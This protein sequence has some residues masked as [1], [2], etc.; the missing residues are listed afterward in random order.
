[1]DETL[2]IIT[3]SLL[4]FVGAIYAIRSFNAVRIRELDRKI[5]QARRMSQVRAGHGSARNE[6]G[7]PQ[8]VEE[9]AEQFGVEDYLDMDEMPEEVERLLPLAKGFIDG[10][11]LQ[12]ILAAGGSP[13]QPGAG[14][15]ADDAWHAQHGF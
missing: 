10:G 2:V 6:S 7:I 5:A 1:M 8:W 13:G 9:L 4:S 15:A 14:Q 3:V 11:G 12:K